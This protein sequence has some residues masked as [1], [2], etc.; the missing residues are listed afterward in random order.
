M[1]RES[2]AIAF[3]RIEG[4]ATFEKVAEII[5]EIHQ[6]FNLSFSKLIKTVIDN[7]S[8]SII[9]TSSSSTETTSTSILNEGKLWTIF[10]SF[11]FN[12]TL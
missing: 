1:N 8:N 12:N 4:S 11:I 6:K 3:K 10:I 5:F 7:D 2:A 9:F